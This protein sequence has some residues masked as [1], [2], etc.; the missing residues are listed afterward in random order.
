MIPMVQLNPRMD[1]IEEYFDF[2]NQFNPFSLKS[3]ARP[4]AVRYDYKT[5]E[6]LVIEEGFYENFCEKLVAFNDY[7][8]KYF[9]ECN[10]K[11]ND[12]LVYIINYLMDNTEYY[13]YTKEVVGKNVKTSVV[14][15]LEETIT[16]IV[17]TLVEKIGN[18]KLEITVET[19]VET[20]KKARGKKK[21]KKKVVTTVDKTVRE[22]GDEAITVAG[23]KIKEI[24]IPDYAK[25]QLAGLPESIKSI[26]DKD[27][28]EHSQYQFELLQLQEVIYLALLNGESIRMSVDKDTNRAYLFKG[29]KILKQIADI[30]LLG[31]NKEFSAQ[32]NN[33]DMDAILDYGKGGKL[34]SGPKL[35]TI[36]K[37]KIAKSIHKYIIKELINCKVYTEKNVY[38]LVGILLEFV[39]V[40]DDERV[41]NAINEIEKQNH[42][43]GKYD[44]Y[45]DYLIKNV[46]AL[47]NPKRKSAF[48]NR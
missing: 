43:E 9:P 15:L 32:Y 33:P 34:I 37:E 31:F 39:F 45:K 25:E 24:I 36:Y 41:Y 7:L 28:Y 14:N 5:P 11:L 23:E 1:V 26:A 46:Q 12:E 13:N 4:D 3:E 10:T 6:Y 2:A 42:P 21:E 18:N 27:Q 44:S 17:K 29:K 40:L 35:S 8:N 47:L 16:T 19:I 22:I 48:K 38:H 30:L 20:I